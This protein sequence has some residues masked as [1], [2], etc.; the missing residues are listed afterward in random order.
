MT[1]PHSSQP[2]WHG[3]FSSGPSDDLLAFTESLSFDVRL[4]RDDIDGSLAHVR[5]LGRTGV[6]TSDEV[7]TI[8]GGLDRIADE[9]ATQTFV[10][11]PSE[12]DVHTAIERRL[13]ELCGPVGGKVHTGRSRNDQ[14]VTA[15]RLWS[16]REL[17]AIATELLSLCD[18]LGDRAREAG[19]G[20]DA[21]CLPGYT[22]VQRAQPV[23]LAHHFL[24]HG[25]A[26]IDRK[27][28]R[29]NSSHSQQSR[30]PSSA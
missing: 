18:T 26:F 5:G 13:T 14:C 16:R 9:F 28:T 29:L 7:S 17:R 8:C 21:V 22:H 2:L 3:R 25:W 15:L 23:L 4:W 6:L 30:M 24:A 20:A 10:F 19:W 27:S 12:E 11:V 1:T